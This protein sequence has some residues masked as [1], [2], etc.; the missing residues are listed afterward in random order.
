MIE[1]NP[2]KNKKE[3]E[4]MKKIL[5]KTSLR[6]Y[7]LFVLGINIGLRI[8]DLLNLKVSDI[9]IGK[10][11]RD[12]IQI[13]EIKT[14]K[15]KIFQ[16]NKNAGVAIRDYLAD[17][18]NLSEEMYLFRSRKGN[19]KPISRIQAWQV[20]NNCANIVGIKDKIGTHTLRKTFGY[21]AYK[22]GIDITLLQ[23]IFNH[24]APSITLRYIGITQDEINDVY[25]NL[26]L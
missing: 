18:N 26:N 17:T 1:V 23:K 4:K 13:K 14:G 15:T 10:K 11:I 20:L 16:I 8:S 9:M 6:D 2:I 24:S 7:C 3:I 25:I 5:K 21:W 19:N 22:Q 12:S